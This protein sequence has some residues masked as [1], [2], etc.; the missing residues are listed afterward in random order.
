MQ[1][2][3][4]LGRG[5]AGKSTLARELG[6]RLGVPVV[7]LDT[8][9]WSAELE[10]TPPARW[11]ELQ[12][13]L[14]AGDRWI[15]D[16][17]LGPY[18]VPAPRLARA[19]TVVVLDFGLPRCAWRALRRSRERADF[20]WWVITW[21]RRWRPPL[22]AAIATHAPAADLRVLRTPRQVR[23]FLSAA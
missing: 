15:L 8:V 6:R 2:V 4:V 12:R 18:D 11:A 1:R 21:R 22:L 20:W 7:G 10:P 14:T 9:F 16:G 17:D 13:E 23:R 19:D 3:V 5:G